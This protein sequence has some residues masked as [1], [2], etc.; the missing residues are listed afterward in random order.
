MTTDTGYSRIRRNAVQ[1][2]QLEQDVLHLT[3]RLETAAKLCSTLD[4]K[5]KYNTCTI[6]VLSSLHTLVYRYH[7]NYHYDLSFQIPLS[8]SDMEATDIVEDR[9]A[10]LNLEL[11][12]QLGDLLTKYQAAATSLEQRGDLLRRASQGLHFSIR[13]NMATWHKKLNNAVFTEQGQ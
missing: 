12:C 8:R 13:G 7:I 11:S 3:S 9:L 2:Q 1:Q 4:I 5:L 10:E 6:L